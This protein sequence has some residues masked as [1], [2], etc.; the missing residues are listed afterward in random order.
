MNIFFLHWNPRICAKWHG[1]KHVL[2]MII[3][4]CQLLASA[5]W[6]TESKYEPQYKLTHK[7]HPCAKW[8]RESLWN[9]KWVAILTKELCKEYTYRYGKV[10]K[11]EGVLV[12]LVKNLPPIKDVGMTCP[13]LAMPDIYKRENEP[14]KSYRLYYKND[15]QK[16]HVWKK[17]DAPDWI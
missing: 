11:C 14:E 7:N 4:C 16:L 8:V 9:Y 10:H 12:D 15:K 3:E 2:K 5:H 1:N 13:A 17:R 6:M